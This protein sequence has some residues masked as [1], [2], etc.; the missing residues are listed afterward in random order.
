MYRATASGKGELTD[1]PTDITAI[2]R[3]DLV[4]FV[5]GCSFSFEQALLE[6]GLPLRHIEQS[7]NV[8][9]SL[10]H[11]NQ[12]GRAVLRTDGGVDATIQTCRRHSCDP[13]HVALSTGPW[14]AGTRRHAAPDRHP[15]FI[16][17]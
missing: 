6:A 16:A 13:D 15:R 10:E 4:T 11:R 8:A 7:R 1:E 17:S 5:I 12:R 3:D 14:L 2:W 9:I